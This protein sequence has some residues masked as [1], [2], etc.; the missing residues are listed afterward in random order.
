VPIGQY[1]GAGP[2]SC[3][4]QRFAVLLSEVDTSAYARGGSNSVSIATDDCAGLR[5]D[6]NGRYALVTVTYNNLGTPVAPQN[7]CRQAVK[8]SFRY[9]NSADDAKDKL[10]WKWRKG[11]AT[12]LL[13]FRDPTAS[14]DYQL[15]VFAETAAAPTLLLGAAVPA[16]A[17]SW[18]VLGDSS[19]KY[20]DLAGAA[21]G[22]KSILL[23]AGAGGTAKILLKGQGAS[24]ADP[25]LPLTLAT[26]AVR[27]QLTNQSN[28]VCW[29]SLFPLSS[30][31]ADDRSIKAAV[32]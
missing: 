32:R 6:A 18:R 27:V 26:T 24:L 29:E 2:C 8:S 22:M 3:S 1:E 4:S 13:D 16:N 25:S 7:G 10:T 17:T 12:A 5:A 15:C 19:Y 28:G 14:S 30:I 9:R 20:A 21:D 23:R 31:T 11:D